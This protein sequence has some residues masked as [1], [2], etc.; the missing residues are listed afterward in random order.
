L[1]KKLYETTISFLDGMIP[2]LTFET[3]NMIF[4]LSHKKAPTPMNIGV[5]AGKPKCLSVL[6]SHNSTVKISKGW[7]TC[8][9]GQTATQKILLARCHTFW[10]KRIKMGPCVS[11]I[12]IETV[13]RVARV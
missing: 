3:L 8:K 5:E 13:S 1:P 9:S 7:Q 10:N 4:D 2:G 11:I 6:S 12:L